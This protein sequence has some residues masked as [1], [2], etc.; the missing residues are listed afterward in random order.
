MNLDITK[1]DG[2]RNAEGWGNCP[3]CGWFFKQEKLDLCP[4][5]RHPWKEP[6]GFTQPAYEPP[7]LS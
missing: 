6:V 3:K 1:S 4:M 5:C 7:S 2:K